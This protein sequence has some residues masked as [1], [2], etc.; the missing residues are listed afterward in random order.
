MRFATGVAVV[1]LLLVASAAFGA[2]FDGPRWQEFEGQ[3]F[4][5]YVVT[6]AVSITWAPGVV[7]TWPEDAPPVGP[8]TLTVGDV[9]LQRVRPVGA[10]RLFTERYEATSELD[11]A[12]TL[13]VARRLL[14]L[15]DVQVASPM[16]ALSPTDHE[17]AWAIT[18]Q[19]LLQLTHA[20]HE[21]AMRRLAADLG[22]DVMRPRGLAPNQWLLKVPQRAPVDAVEASMALAEA[23]FT[24]WA[25]V[26]WVVPKY[27]RYTPADPRYADQW[28]LNN[29]GQV[30]G[31]PDNDMDVAEAWDITLGD[32]TVIVSAQDSGVQLDHPDLAED[33]LPGYDFVNGDDDPSPGSS[34]GTSVAGCMAA[35]ENGEGVLGSC[36]NCKILPVRMLGADN[37]GEADAHDFSVANGAAVI[38]NSWGPSDSADPS[39]PQPIPGVVATAVEY[40]VA[41]GRDGMGVAIFWAGGNGNNAGQ[42]CSQDGYVSHPDTIAVGASTNTGSRSSYSERCPELDISAPSAGG[43]ASIVTTSSNSSGYTSNFGGTSAASPNAAGVGALVLSA[44]PELT[45]DQLR[46]LLRNTAE[47]IDPGDAEYDFNG[48]S[49]SY[50]YG[51]VNA[52]AALEGQVATLTISTGPLRCDEQV[53][54]TVGIPTA[55]EL[56]SVTVQATSSAE[57][58][59][60]T[61]TLLEAAEGVFEGVVPLTTDPATPNDGVLS[62]VDG[63]GVIVGSVEADAAKQ[64]TVD[65]V[66]PTLSAFEVRE[67]TPTSAILYWETDEPA[68]GEATWDG[69]SGTD[70]I[71]DLDHLAL[72]L[73]LT[74]CTNYSASL[75]STDS[76][77]QSGTVEDALSWR[78][79]GDPVTLPDGVLPDA[80]PCDPSTWYEPETP[81]DDDDATARGPGGFEGE[82]GCTSCQSS[83]AAAGGGTWTLLGL[84]GLLGA[85][86]R[87]SALTSS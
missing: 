68:D 81:A 71:V 43:T 67:I 17:D 54:V 26:D 53:Q 42:T 48:H 52:L 51:R 46:E 22:I 45:F 87:R 62:V 7:A 63:D 60:E 75:T 30:A 32:E 61:I 18:D 13:R 27:P 38:N 35:P 70:P 8:E 72:A 24:R 6:G 77:G 64:V 44:L 40:A 73:N 33:L 2:P 15:P 50:G 84:L 41:S 9:T 79:P 39:T 12:G 55:T 83:V 21:S 66:G 23:P 25:E 65:C 86:R 80:D 57:P 76:A 37:A 19:V 16:W 36:P 28:H 20:G 78:A 34:H 56:E 85:R 58:G 4:P 3:R 82:G 59:G 29:T 74:P 5:L 14:A 31:I 1:S 10:N 69:G 47:K 49:L 11:A